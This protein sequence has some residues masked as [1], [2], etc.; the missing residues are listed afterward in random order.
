MKPE[1][2]EKE[3]MGETLRFQRN[4]TCPWCG[5]EFRDSWE[6]S[7]GEYDCDECGGKF[8][9]ERDVTVEYSTTRIKKG[10]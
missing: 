4:I 1:D 8:E 7:E 9:A 2:I 10:I 6:M 5:Y 3:I